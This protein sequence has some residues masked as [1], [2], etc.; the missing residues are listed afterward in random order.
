MFVVFGLAL[1]EIYENKKP[2]GRGEMLTER[3]WIYRKVK[4]DLS[5]SG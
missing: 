4:P 2:G 3:V 1:I 5:V